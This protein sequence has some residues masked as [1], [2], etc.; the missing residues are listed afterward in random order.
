TKYLP[1][2]ALE[3]FLPEHILRRPKKGFGI[4]VAKWINAE[5]K[6][7]VDE[8]LDPSYIRKQGIFSNGYVQQLLIEHRTGAA[9]RRKELWTLLMF[10][11][12]WSKYLAP[13]A[14]RTAAPLGIN[15]R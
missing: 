7:L 11:R 13:A 6:P 9:D 2:R 14:A 5:F 4:P 8:L 3:P 1:K 10:Q 15:I 12:W